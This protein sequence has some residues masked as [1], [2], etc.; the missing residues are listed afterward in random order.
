MLQHRM[1]DAAML[2]L[3]ERERERG[4]RARGASKG[5]QEIYN[6]SGPWIRVQTRGTECAGEMEGRRRSGHVLVVSTDDS[7]KQSQSAFV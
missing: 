3:R 2:R 5:G 7:T 1:G 6:M 4:K